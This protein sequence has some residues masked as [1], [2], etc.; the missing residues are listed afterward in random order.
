MLVC[1]QCQVQELLTQKVIDMERRKNKSDK[2]FAWAGVR[3]SAFFAHCLFFSI[4]VCLRREKQFGDISL[5]GKIFRDRGG[6]SGSRRF[7]LT[8]KR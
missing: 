5:I 1:L 2:E 7:H 4:W 6:E 8:I 3:K